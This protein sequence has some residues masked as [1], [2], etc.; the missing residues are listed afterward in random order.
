MIVS[1]VLLEI[2]IA[3]E[4]ASTASVLTNAVNCYTICCSKPFP[5]SD[6]RTDG[7]GHPNTDDISDQKWVS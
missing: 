4:E 7:D 6:M 3:Q 1:N 5:T 2:H